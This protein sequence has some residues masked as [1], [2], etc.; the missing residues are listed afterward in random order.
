M[1]VHDDL[2]NVTSMGFLKILL[3]ILLSLAIL[4]AVFLV[5]FT[6]TDYRPDEVETL[7]VKDSPDVIEQDTLSVMIW[8]I[9]YAGLGND[10]SFFYDGGDRVRASGER[11]KQNL[12]AITRELANNKSADLYLLQE[13]DVA[14]KRSYH[15]DQFRRIHSALGSYNGYFALNYRV[16]F[17]PLPPHN[18]LGKVTSGLASFSSF[19]PSRVMR[20]D[21]PGG[22]G[23]PKR[24]FMLDRCF[25]TLR[26]PMKEGQDLVVVNTHNS[27]YDTGTLKK[28]EMEHLRS[29]LLSEYEKGNYLI[30]GGDWNQFPTGIHSHEDTYAGMDSAK[31][32]TIEPDFMPQGWRWG[33][34]PATPT[35]RSLKLPYRADTPT[36]VIDF[37]LVSPNISLIEVQTIPLNFQPSDHHPVRARFHLQ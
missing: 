28:K 7:A 6:L 16:Q 24:L 25:M 32:T 20:H 8:N 33:Y 37:Y 27:A 21:M 36:A 11:V 4:F 19:I 31:T 14:S 10:M 35:N 34:D 9:G 1:Y 29:F 30:V 2:L 12:D 17:V 13:V 22:Y 18:P 15:T 3:Y 23:W 26:F 5:Y